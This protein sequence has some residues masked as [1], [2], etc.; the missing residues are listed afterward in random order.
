MLQGLVSR[1]DSWLYS[2]IEEM[3]RLSSKDWLLIHIYNI[4]VASSNAKAYEKHKFMI[5]PPKPKSMR[6][7]ELHQKKMT[8]NQA[9][10]FFSHVRVEEASVQEN[11]QEENTQEEEKENA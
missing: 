11:I 7:D 10:S 3:P 1:G 4:N 5:K 9:R 2:K 6:G 8:L